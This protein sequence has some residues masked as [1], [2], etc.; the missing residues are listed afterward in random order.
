M[1]ETYWEPGLLRF[2]RVYA[3]LRLVFLLWLPVSAGRITARFGDVS[4]INITLVMIVIAAEML[5]LLGYLAVP[6]FQRKL[7]Q[8]YLPVALIFAISGVIIEAHIFSPLAGL[9]QPV[10]F[11]YILLILVAWQYTYREVL[12]FTLGSALLEI[13]LIFFIPAASFIGFEQLGLPAEFDEFIRFGNIAGRSLSFLVLGY[14][15]T[16]LM[17]A[18]RSQRAR[19]IQVNQRLVQ[20]AAT[21]EQLTI[22]R[23]R[24]RISRE[25]HD[26]L[27][28]TLSAMAVQ[29]DAFVA[30]WEDIPEKARGMIDQML[31]TTRTGL[32]ETRRALRALRAEPLEEMGL[33]L[34]V[35]TLAEDFAA[36]ES[37]QLDLAIPE[38]LD[39]LSLEV[40][41]CYFRVAQEA[42]E[43]IARHAS[44]QRLSVRMQG[45]GHGLR[46]TVADDGHG[47]DVQSESAAEKFGLIGMRDRADLIGAKLEVVSQPDQ[48]TTIHLIL[49]NG[50]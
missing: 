8:S 17:K 27:A 47:F 46:M 37:L 14:I 34:A 45:N 26:T 9:W 32:D 28:H 16:S 5:F 38:H 7:A 49:E 19:L 44:A 40:E 20:H 35:R 1:K 25:L 48:G 24:N 42:L 22:S 50:P 11:L 18:Q 6:W 29:L 39:H 2:F 23:E 4:D 12:A 43:N 21:L 31:N 15:V 3:I 13:I 41:Q 33:A 36:R 10:P 30:V